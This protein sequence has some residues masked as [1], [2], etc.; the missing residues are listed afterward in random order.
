MPLGGFMLVGASLF[1][2]LAYVYL[3]EFFQAV[4][5]DMT[6]S[7]L[8]IEDVYGRMN[9]LAAE[10]PSGAAGLTVDTRFGGVRGEASF[11]GMI[12][13]ISPDNL[14][15]ADLTRAFVEGMV[16]ELWRLVPPDIIT[17]STRVIATGN[18]VRK[19]SIVPAVIQSIT[20]ITP[21]IAAACEEAAVGAACVA[22]VAL[23]L[24]EPKDIVP[25][26]ESY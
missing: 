5:R 20:G 8:P 9:A 15:P 14:T 21:L 18:A 3:A 10:S 26:L 2:G 17:A 22:A 1:G 11:R 13:G 24:L 4:T 7:E 23:G 19:N 16:T 25:Q 6:G 12:S